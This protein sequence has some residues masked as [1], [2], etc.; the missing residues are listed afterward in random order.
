MLVATSPML[1]L[2]IVVLMPL[3]VGPLLM[4]GR[5]VRRLSRDSQDRVADASAL[6]AETINAVQ[7][8][9]AFTLEAWVQRVGDGDDVFQRRLAG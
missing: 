1:T 9:Q 4:L 6:A 8:V 7:T 5:R 2:M 3:I